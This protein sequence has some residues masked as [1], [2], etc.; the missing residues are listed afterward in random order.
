[1]RPVSFS[2]TGSCEEPCSYSWDFGDGAAAS[3]PSP[4]HAYAVPGS[5]PVR[6][7]VTND[8]GNDS[9]QL[10]IAVSSCWSPG[11]PAQ[12]GSCYGGP[13]Q[14]T[15]AAGVAWLWST[16]AT[17]RSVTV[18]PAGA[19]WVDVNSGS[20]CWGHAPWTVVLDNCGDPGGDVN[21]DGR[22]DAADLPALLRELSDGDGTAVTAA[23]GGDLSA[24]GGDV[25]RDW[26]LTSADVEAILGIL[27]GLP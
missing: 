16:G 22:T 25:T 14:L 18:V 23:G 10:P 6:L 8:G 2:F 19:Y 15:A 4:T 26:L 1:V 27:F 11:S 17:T 3:I 20:S 7:T 5:Y 24:P 9:E 13:V 21:L 12:S